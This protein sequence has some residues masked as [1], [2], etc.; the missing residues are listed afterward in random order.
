M[1]IT[2]TTDSAEQVKA[3]LESRGFEASEVVDP[4]VEQAAEET[5]AETP[6]EEVQ[7]ETPA[8]AEGTGEPAGTTDGETVPGSE[9]DDDDEQEPD[10]PAPAGGKPKGKRGGF[11]KKI[12]KLTADKHRLEGELAATRRQLEGKPAG[13]TPADQPVVDQGPVKPTRPKLADFDGDWDKYESAQSV[14]EEK[15][16]EYDRSIALK[17]FNE[18]R[19]REQL[20]QVQQQIQGQ[21]EQRKTAVMEK[22]DDYEEVIESLVAAGDV[23]FP[24]YLAE[25]FMESPQGPEVMYHL[26]K[27]V[28]EAKRIL[29]LSPRMQLL[30]IGKIE[31]TLEANS[32]EKPTETVPATPARAAA[33]APAQNQKPTTSKAP[34]PIKPVGA[35]TATNTSS[36]AEAAERGDFK[37]Y[38]K[39]RQAGVQI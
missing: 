28:D 32:K 7:T 14:Y 31:A 9:P 37:T 1:V 22:F 15:K 34:T 18:Q 20:A 33:P 3:A 39:L 25:A 6:A 17:E 5:P 27:N 36:L 2:S 26:A 12:D 29:A 16:T 4:D 13:E 23:V 8:P 19:Q 24:G 38:E 21:F 30:E 10:E 11:Q 35:R